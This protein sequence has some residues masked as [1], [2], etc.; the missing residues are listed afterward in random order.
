MTARGKTAATNS[1]E[2]ISA[3]ECMTNR[4]GVGAVSGLNTHRGSYVQFSDDPP[5]EQMSN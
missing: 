4:S 3:D 5:Y 2:S 1:H